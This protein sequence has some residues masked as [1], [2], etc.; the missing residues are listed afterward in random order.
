MT[1]S[2]MN[3]ADNSSTALGSTIFARLH[4]TTYLARFLDNAIRPD[5][6]S[7]EAFRDV[8][9]GVSTIETAQG[10]AIV[11]YGNSTIIA[12]VKGEFIDI[13][14]IQQ[15]AD[16]DE[17]DEDDMQIDTNKLIGLGPI[18]KRSLVVGVD[19]TPMSSAKF[20]SGP[21]GEEAQVLASRLM[22]S[23]DV[24]PPFSA[25]SLNIQGTSLRWC[26]F[27]DLVCL[28]YDGNLL[29]ACTLA[30]NAALNDTKLPNTQSDDH[31]LVCSSVE[32]ETKPL[33]LLSSPQTFTFGIVEGTH[34]LS[35]PNAFESTMIS[36][37]ITIT[38]DTMKLDT[39]EDM[40]GVQCSGR[41]SALITTEEARQ[42]EAK[43]RKQGAANKLRIQD[44][45]LVKICLMRA[46]RH[47][48]QVKQAMQNAQR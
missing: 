36:A 21:P 1:A 24:C 37:S 15:T 34:L 40:V 12:G 23:F 48:A 3:A 22:R 31:G 7:F 33:S 18:D 2:T 43:G 28:S 42:A 19:L 32:S 4:P 14:D 27:V 6:R 10:S 46:R 41:C 39:E 30:V 29:D 38:L 25:D 35:D 20:K 47:C 16:V 8:S 11:R 45:E 17:G 9:V 44:E 5:G 26:L 13:S